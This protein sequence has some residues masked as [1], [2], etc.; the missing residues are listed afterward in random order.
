VWVFILNT[1]LSCYDRGFIPRGEVSVFTI[2]M[3]LSTEKLIDLT[4]LLVRKNMV[5]AAILCLRELRK[6]VAER[7]EKM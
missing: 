6:R 2:P 5:D 1:N 7:S 3:K 4:I